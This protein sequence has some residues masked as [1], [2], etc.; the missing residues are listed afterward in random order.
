M[1]RFSVLQIQLHLECYY[2]IKKD[3]SFPKCVKK[4]RMEPV[5]KGKEVENLQ[6]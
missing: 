3:K 5:N 1:C 4:D 2:F 6:L